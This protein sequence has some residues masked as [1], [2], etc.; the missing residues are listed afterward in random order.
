MI[1]VKQS[2]FFKKTDFFYTISFEMKKSRIFAPVKRELIAFF[3]IYPPEF[4][5][6]NIKNR[7][8]R[9]E[10]KILIKNDLCIIF[11]KNPAWLSDENMR[12]VVR[13]TK[14]VCRFCTQTKN[15]FI[16]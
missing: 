13:C 5:T 12:K 15:S 1:F 2:A 6:V 11:P 7:L 4:S 8:M 9:V 16:F 14:S 10:S 3:S